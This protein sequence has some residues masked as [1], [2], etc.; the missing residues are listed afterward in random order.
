PDRLAVGGTNLRQGG[1]RSRGWRDRLTH[2]GPGLSGFETSGEGH[3]D[4]VVPGPQE[5]D[6]AR[7]DRPS[8]LRRRD[9]VGSGVDGRGRASPRPGQG[10]GDP[11]FQSAEENGNAAGVESLIANPWSR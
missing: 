8:A 4:D 7:H 10:G 1:S 11:V 5:D 6:R 9:D 2:A 3:D